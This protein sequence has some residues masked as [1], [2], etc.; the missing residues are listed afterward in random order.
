I[1]TS[2]TSTTSGTRG[3]HGSAS[4][5]HGTRSGRER[6]DEFQEGQ[7]ARSI[8]Q[9]TA[10]LPSDLFLWAAG[11]A[12]L[13]SLGFQVLGMVRQTPRSMMSQ[14]RHPEV[15]P[16]PLSSFVGMWVPSLLLLDVYNKIVKVV[17]SDRRD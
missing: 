4:S 1:G 17:G 6:S 12:V 10:K 3:S 15:R 9:R 8:E 14:V 5:S 13:G 11:A 7:V 16:A 2:G